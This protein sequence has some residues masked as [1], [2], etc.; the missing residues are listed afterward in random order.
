MPLIGLRIDCKAAPFLSPNQRTTRVRGRRLV[1]DARPHGTFRQSLSRGRASRTSRLLRTRVVRWLG[2]K[3]G[4]AL[5]SR[6]RKT[7]I[8]NASSLRSGPAEKPAGNPVWLSPL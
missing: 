4:A 5:Q 7:L 3:K 1:R 2:D 8:Q 6:L